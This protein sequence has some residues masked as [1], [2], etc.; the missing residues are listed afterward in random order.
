MALVLLYL[1]I[2]SGCWDGDTLFAVIL[3]IFG[4]LALV[5]GICLFIFAFVAYFLPF[6][7]LVIE[8]LHISFSGFPDWLLPFVVV[9]LAV[10]IIS[11]VVKFL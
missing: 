9:L 11:L 6:I 10:A 2:F 3:Q 1:H 8:Y 5:A 7:S 4:V